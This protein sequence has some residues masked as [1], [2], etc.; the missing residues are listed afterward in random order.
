M[1][2]IMIENISL[3][4]CNNPKLLSIVLEEHGRPNV[5]LYITHMNTHICC[6]AFR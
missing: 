2:N 3:S 5:S 4:K 1:V 6:V